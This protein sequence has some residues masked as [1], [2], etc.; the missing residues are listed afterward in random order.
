MHKTKYGT[1]KMALEVLFY[2]P[3]GSSGSIFWG[4]TAGVGPVNARKTAVLS[5]FFYVID[6]K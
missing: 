2:T 4:K 3:L 1:D 6:F 5:V